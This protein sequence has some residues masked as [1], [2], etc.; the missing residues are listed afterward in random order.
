MKRL[1]IIA[2][3]LLMILT[4]AGCG[5]TQ[6]Q[7][8]SGAPTDQKQAGTVKLKTA[9]EI[10]TALKAKGLPVGKVIVYTAETDTNKLLGRPN[11]YTSK[12]N[13]ADT[14]LEQLDPNNPN[15]GSVEFFTSASDARTRKDY[16]DNIG[17]QSP[18]FV[19]YSYINGT[20]LLRLSKDLTK[21]QAAQ[22]EKAFKEL[23]I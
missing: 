10:S 20:A 22:Y 3:S 2:L 14:S 12:V 8:Q 5:S 4:V 1:S 13:F 17:K 6:T 7:T 18:M 16:I 21:D 15:G 11:Q 23:K 9:E 19:E